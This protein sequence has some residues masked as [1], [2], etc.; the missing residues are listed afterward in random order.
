M[1]FETFL[2]LITLIGTGAAGAITTWVALKKSLLEIKKIKIDLERENKELKIQLY[3]LST[4][5]VMRLNIISDLQE[6]VY[7]VFNET[8][9]DRFIMF[10][11]NNGKTDFNRTTAVFEQHRMD[12]SGSISVGATK[13]Y[14][15]FKFDDTYRNML[16]RIETIGMEVIYTK[17]MQESDLKAI[18]EYEDIVAA[19]VFFILREHINESH[20]RVW[21]ASVAI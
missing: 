18:Y 20:D 21:Y 11:A 7:K 5:I 1:S 2:T 14:I 17:E 13:R 6:L 9:A 15:N 4:P 19:K 10:V 16:K 3:D 12:E 8:A